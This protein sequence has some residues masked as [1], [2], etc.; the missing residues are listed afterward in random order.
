MLQLEFSD[1]G[2]RHDGFGED[3]TFRA[4]PVRRDQQ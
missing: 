2:Q 3:G 1:L 4:A